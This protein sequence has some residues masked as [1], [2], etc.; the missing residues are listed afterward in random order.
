VIGTPLGILQLVLHCK[1]RKRRSTEEPNKQKE[2]TE[3]VDLE[4]GNGK[5]RVTF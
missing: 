1:Y 2:S 3:K 5:E 4:M